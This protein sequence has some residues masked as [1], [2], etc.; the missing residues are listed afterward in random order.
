MMIIPLGLSLLKASS[1]LTRELHASRVFTL[2][3][4]ALLFDLAPRRVWLFSLQRLPQTSLAGAELSALDILSVP[5]FLRLLLGFHRSVPWK[6]VTLCAT[7]WSPD[8]PLGDLSKLPT[9]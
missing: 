5:L 2:T 4:G 8:F 7:L 9:F 1:D 6:G 3:D